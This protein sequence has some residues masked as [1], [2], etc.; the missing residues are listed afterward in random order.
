MHSISMPRLCSIADSSID[1]NPPEAALPIMSGAMDRHH[2]QAL[3]G[4]PSVCFRSFM[5]LGGPAL[6]GFSV[7]PC[8]ALMADRLGPTRL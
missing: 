2:D 1:R 3:S 8:V 6:L 5:R 4:R 7:I